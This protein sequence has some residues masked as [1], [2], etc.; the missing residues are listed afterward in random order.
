LPPARK[1]SNLNQ[2]KNFAQDPTIG[3]TGYANIHKLKLMGKQGQV[4]SRMK[5]NSIVE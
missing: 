3:V 4:D 1:I 2:P 5:L